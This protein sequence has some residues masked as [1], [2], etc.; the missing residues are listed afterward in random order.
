MVTASTPPVLAAGSMQDRIRLAVEG[1]ILSG[2]R[3]PGSTIDDR[4]LAARFQASRTPVRE[5]LLMLAAQGL[6]H[7]APRAGIY[8]RRASID[9]LVAALEAVGELESVLAGLAA[10]RASPA[11]HDRLR[12]AL[13]TASALAEAGD[14]RGYDSANLALHDAIYAGS[15]NPVLVDTVR[16]LRRR[17]AAYRQRSTRHPG[18][19]KASDSE[20]RRIV[21]AIVAGD[22]G[23]ASDA[24]RQHIGLGGEALVQLV[25]AAQALGAP[26]AT[27]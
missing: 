9:E 17:L 19:L 14:L 7:I 27:G 25:R 16:Q 26:D 11:Q 21:E 5:A 15:G 6:V 2:E 22:A 1:E 23:T 10:R 13:A 18:R 20:H 12:E 4:A 24:M 3:P 8:V